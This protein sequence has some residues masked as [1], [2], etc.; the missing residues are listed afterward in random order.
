VSSNLEKANYWLLTAD[1]TV[2]QEIDRRT[3]W[4]AGATTGHWLL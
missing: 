2:L 4:Q 3:G 1:L